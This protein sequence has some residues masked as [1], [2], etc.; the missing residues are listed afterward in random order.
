VI[1][2]KSPLS[3]V[4]LKDKAEDVRLIAHDL[5]FEYTESAVPG[6]PNSVRFAF[7]L[8]QEEFFRLLNVV[9]RDLFARRG[10]LR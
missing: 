3:I 10:F 6:E 5:G 8:T 7:A 9:P 1:L 2:S 4:A